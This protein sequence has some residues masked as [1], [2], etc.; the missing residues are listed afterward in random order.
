MLTFRRTSLPGPETGARSAGLGFELSWISHIKDSQA[1][2]FEL[3][4][5]TALSNAA[6]N[7]VDHS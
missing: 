3:P 4:A 5:A 6:K 7:R 2:K 1:P